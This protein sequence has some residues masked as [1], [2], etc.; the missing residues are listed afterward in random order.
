MQQLVCQTALLCFYEK[1]TLLGREDLASMLGVGLDTAAP[2][3]IDIE[4]FLHGL[5]SVSQELVRGGTEHS[6]LPLLNARAHR[7]GW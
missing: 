3:F 7:R 2:F 6:M 4:D 1:S 5:C